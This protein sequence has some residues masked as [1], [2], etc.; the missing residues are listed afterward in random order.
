[1]NRKSLTHTDHLRKC[2]NKEKWP[3]RRVGGGLVA[4]GVGLL[5]YSIPPLG[6]L[7]PSPL[8]T[9]T[10]LGLSA[11][12]TAFQIKN[13]ESYPQVTLFTIH[14]ILCRPSARINYSLAPLPPAII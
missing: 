6:S 5:Y 1:V 2:S 12:F 8:S 7:V 11:H 3:I 10:F 4:A 13:P 14:S 9:A